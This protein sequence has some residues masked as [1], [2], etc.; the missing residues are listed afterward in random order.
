MKKDAVGIKEKVTLI[1]SRSNG[2]KVVIVVDADRPGL[3][4]RI[5]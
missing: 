5:D 1:L 2:E 4:R 3:I